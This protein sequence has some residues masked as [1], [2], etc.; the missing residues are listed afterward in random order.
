MP[1][2]IALLYR[3]FLKDYVVNERGNM[4]Y[5][6]RNSEIFPELND[7]RDY[8]LKNYGGKKTKIFIDEH[9]LEEGGSGLEKK[10]KKAKIK[11]TD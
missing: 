9:C 1:K 10:L 4:V 2:Q 8:I 11:I 5:E 7:A 6:P 3:D